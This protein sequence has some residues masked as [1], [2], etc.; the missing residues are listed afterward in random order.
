MGILSG[1]HPAPKRGIAVL[2]LCIM[3][4]SASAQ[5]ADVIHNTGFE[6]RGVTNASDAGHFLMRGTYGPTQDQI[7]HLMAVG[8]ET[9]V[10]QQMSIPATQHQPQLEAYG[11]NVGGYERQRVWFDTALDAPDQLRQRV[12]FALSEILVVSDNNGALEG[13]AIALTQYYD[14]LLEHAFGNYRDLLEDVT[15][16]PTMGHYLS[17]FRSTRDANV[18][19]E[20]DENYAREIMQLF[21]IGLYML[22][23]DGT[24]QLDGMNNPIPTYEQH[25]IIALAEAFT[26]WNFAGADADDGNCEWW[27]WR[28]PERN[29]LLPME[30]CVI[31]NPDLNNQPANY[32]VTTEKTIVGD[33]VL[34]AGQTAEED[35]QDAL[36]TLFNHPNVGPF[37]SYRLIQ[38]LV[39]SNPT[40]AYVERVAQVFN[41]NGG[42]VRGDLGAVIRTILLDPEALDGRTSVANFGKMKEPLVMLTQL[43]RAYPM[44]WNPDFLSTPENHWPGSIYHPE[45]YFSQAAMRSPSVFNFFQPDYAPPGSILDQGLVAPEFQVMTEAQVVSMANLFYYAYAAHESGEYAWMSENQLDVNSLLPLAGNA[46]A[47]VDALNETLLFGELDV[48]SRQLIIDQL[49][50]NVP[51]NEAETRVRQALY[52]IFTAPAAYV[53][54]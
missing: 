38:R 21:S 26:G 14:I 24:R 41:D 35:M 30:P 43:W 31:T 47:L 12:A 1:F 8:F 32:H 40:P 9:W 50:D 51:A 52:L 7:N 45:D 37:I 46:S 33:V 34:P 16:T 25:H 44:Q 22:N 20:P 28:W 36:D 53:Q 11:L 23:N 27:E 4:S 13:Q 2:L 15:L 42:G 39:T 6:V 3:G 10:A 54:L 18:G 48:V 17:M 19:I 49:E 29:F 5:T